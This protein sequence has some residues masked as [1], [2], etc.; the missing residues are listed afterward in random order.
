M[1]SDFMNGLTDTWHLDYATP[2]LLQQ[3]LR[4]MRESDSFKTDAII[5]AVLRLVVRLI[6]TQSYALGLWYSRRAYERSRGEMIT[7]LYEKTLSRK[8]IGA[9]AQPAEQPDQH[10]DGTLKVPTESMTRLQ[11][12]WKTL[13]C[14]ISAPPRSR[15]EMAKQPASMGKILNL[16][17]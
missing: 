8:I 14:W 9:H 13:S 1:D 10:V 15:K 16:M 4:S 11:I 3:L 5:Y 2:V 17:Q 6:G 12:F 7:M